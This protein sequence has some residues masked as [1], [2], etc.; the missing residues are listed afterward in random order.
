MASLIQPG[1]KPLTP[2]RRGVG[3]VLDAVLAPQCLSCGAITEGTAAGGAGAL[4]GDCWREV[5]F[6]SAPMCAL[7]G[8]PFELGSSVQD[9]A[10]LC[11]AC[12]RHAPVFARA[13]AVFA[14]DAASRGLILGF[15]HADKTHGAPA[16]AQWMARAGA[17]LLAE[18]DLIVPV[19]LHRWRLFTRRYNQAALLAGSLVLESCAREGG[20]AFVPDLLIR[21]R[22]TPSQGRLSRRA[23]LLNVRGAFTVNARRGDMLKGRR[24]LLVDDVYTTGATVDAAARA[25]L[26]GGAAAVDV[27]T[28]ARVVRPT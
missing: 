25:L 3:M 8:Y 9:G 27:L 28:L 19:P 7:C 15:K 24:V 11:G 14:Y 2:W 4:C 12:V 5:T 18:A 22:A 26:A 13:R 16:Y 1:P 23:R 10:S 21:T 17:E 20:K 6:V